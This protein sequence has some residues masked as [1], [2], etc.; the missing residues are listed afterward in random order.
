MAAMDRDDELR[1]L[2][3]NLRVRLVRIPTPAF[4]P[5]VMSAM[6][7]YARARGVEVRTSS[8]NVTV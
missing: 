7:E 8:Y 1:Q 3:Q 4:V 5:R 2:A 6:L